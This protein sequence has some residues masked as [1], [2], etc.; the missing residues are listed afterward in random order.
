[1]FYF[2][3][4]TSELP[5]ASGHNSFYV[6]AGDRVANLTPTQAGYSILKPHLLVFNSEADN[7]SY[8][9]EARK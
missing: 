3:A 9:I 2:A 1:V 7:G 6:K 4:T 8:K 5:S